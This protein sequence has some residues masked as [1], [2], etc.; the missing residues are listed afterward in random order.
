MCA[1]VAC[2]LI[3]DWRQ[4]LLRHEADNA[5]AIYPLT[6]EGGFPADLVTEVSFETGLSTATAM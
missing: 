3:R 4:D 6:R 1:R 5:G 2:S